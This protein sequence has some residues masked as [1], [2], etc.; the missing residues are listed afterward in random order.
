[1][2]NV[3]L[4]REIKMTKPEVGMLLKQITEDEKLELPPA[5]GTVPIPSGY[6]RLYHQTSAQNM[7]SIKQSGIRFEHAKGYEG[8]EAIYADEKGFYGKPGDR[9]TV[10]FAIP[11]DRWHRPFVQGD[12][13]PSEIIA[14]HLPWHSKARYIEKKPKLIKQAISGELDHL[15]WTYHDYDTVP[16]EYGPAIEYIKQKYGQNNTE[17]GFEESKMSKIGDFLGRLV[18]ADL[19]ETVGSVAALG[20]SPSINLGM[21]PEPFDAQTPT[22]KKKRRKKK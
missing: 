4:S 15:C 9:P 22:P 17:E 1:M 16:E 3:C 5:P 12:V 7:P 19:E 14:C 8:P 21:A 20:T 13:D 18:E 2:V 10:E 6:V 11:Q